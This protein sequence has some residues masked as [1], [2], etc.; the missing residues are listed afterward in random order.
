MKKYYCKDGQ[1][2]LVKPHPNDSKKI[3]VVYNN[4]K[5]C[6]SKNIIDKT[7]FSQD[8]TR[9]GYNNTVILTDPNTNKILL[10]VKICET[11]RESTYKRCGGSYYGAGVEIKQIF[12][13]TGD[14]NE[15]QI[16]SIT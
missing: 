15:T 12:K 16:I 3:I 11:E 4:K 5:Y 13:N 14:A 2:V 8:P 7:I 6:R 1:V 10:K 9:V